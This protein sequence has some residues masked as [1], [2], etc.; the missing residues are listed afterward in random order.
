MV[1]PLALLI[2]CSAFF[3]C[4]ET[5]LLSLDRY[6]LRL[7]T[8]QGPREARRNNWPLLHNS[9][10]RGTLLFGCTLVSVSVAALTSWT[11]LHH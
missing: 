1:G 2:A 9:R 3:S 10:L 4:I 8:E 5:A 6:R 11:V 7:Q